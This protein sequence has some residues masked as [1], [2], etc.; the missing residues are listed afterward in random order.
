MPHVGNALGSQENL[1]QGTAC[2]IGVGGGGGGKVGWLG[3]VS[4]VF[5]VK[6]GKEVLGGEAIND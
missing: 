5:W 1:A 2:R 6:T 4:G 3:G